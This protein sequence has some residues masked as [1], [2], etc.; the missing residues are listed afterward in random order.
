[1]SDTPDKEVSKIHDTAFLR[2][3]EPFD[4]ILEN[5]IPDDIVHVRTPSADRLSAFGKSID[6]FIEMAEEFVKK[7]SGR[8]SLYFVAIVALFFFV[9]WFMSPES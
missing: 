1:M 3:F 8:F 5:E 7:H 4:P 2:R 6:T 9:M